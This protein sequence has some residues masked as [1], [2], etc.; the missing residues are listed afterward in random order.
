[1]K[2]TSVFHVFTSP[3]VNEDIYLMSGLPQ[4]LSGKEYA[5]CAEVRLW[6]LSQEDPLEKEMAT[7]SSIFVW[8]IPWTQEPGML[9]S[10]G[11]QSW[12]QRSD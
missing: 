7:H 10:M 6:S 8:S 5:C 11:S 4:R 9:Q 2:T 3:S 1:M 12:T